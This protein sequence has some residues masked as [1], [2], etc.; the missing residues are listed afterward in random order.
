MMAEFHLAASVSGSWFSSC[1]FTGNTEHN[2]VVTVINN[3]GAFP[4]MTNQN[5]CCEK[6]PYQLVNRYSGQEKIDRSL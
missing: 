2:N 3:A 4:T 5:V 6:K 1:S